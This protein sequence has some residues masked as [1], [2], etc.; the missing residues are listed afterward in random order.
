MQ[1]TILLLGAIL[2]AL[3][4]AQY[5]A[6]D[7]AKKSAAYAEYCSQPGANETLCN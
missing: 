3:L 7:N 4:L 5:A 2:F 6:V 1:S